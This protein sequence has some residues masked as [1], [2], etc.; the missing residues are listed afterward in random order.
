MKTIGVISDTHGL[1]RPE[2]INSFK[3][4]EMIIHAGDVGS[5]DVLAKLEEMAPVVAVRGNCDYSSGVLSLPMTQMVEVGNRCFYVLH[6][7]AKLDLE[8]KAAGIDCV[9]FGHSHK[10][11]AFQRGGILYLNPGSAG[12]KRFT[13][14]VGVA[15]LYVNDERIDYELI[16]LME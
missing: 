4:V 8:P 5:L 11:E 16:T 6:A 14:P 15:K 12:P 13:L 10:P 2:V 7:L 9:I 3:D 1:L